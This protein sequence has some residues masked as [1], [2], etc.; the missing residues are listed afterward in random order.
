MFGNTKKRPRSVQVLFVVY[1]VSMLVLILL[2]ASNYPVQWRSQV[3]HERQRYVEVI[4]Q[5]LRYYAMDHGGQ[6]PD[7]PG[8]P[9]MIANTNDCEASCPALSKQLSC[10]NLTQVLVPSY[11]KEMLEDPLNTSEKE[12]GF[13]ITSST[14]GVLIGSCNTFFGQKVEASYSNE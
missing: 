7:L 5:A 14:V 2:A 1:G 4:A 13:Y 11:M 6:L 9:A 12:S 10:F 8:E 3:N